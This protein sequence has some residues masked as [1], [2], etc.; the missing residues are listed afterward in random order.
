MTLTFNVDN[1]NDYDIHF[2]IDNLFFGLIWS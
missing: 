2:G 1:Y